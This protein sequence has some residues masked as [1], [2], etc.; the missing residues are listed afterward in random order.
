MV[1][2]NLNQLPEFRLKPNLIALGSSCSRVGKK[3]L[4]S[5]GIAQFN[6]VCRGFNLGNLG[7]AI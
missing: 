7:R 3:N 1:E 6:S 5:T 2:R 4:F